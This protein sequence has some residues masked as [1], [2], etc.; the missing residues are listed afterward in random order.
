MVLSVILCTHNPRRDYLDRTLAALQTQS[1]DKGK[2]ELLVI[3]NDSHPPLR[4]GLDLSWH[5][6][7]RI[8]EEPDLGIL[9][10]RVRGLR[11]ASAS[12]MLFVDDDNVLAPDYLETALEIANLHP[13]LGCWGGSLT[14][15]F[16]VPPPPWIETFKLFLACV[17]VPEDRWSNLRFSHAT[18]PPTAGMCL[19]RAVAKQFIHLVETDPRRQLLGRRGKTGLTNG[20]DA[21]LAYTACDIGL[22]TGQFARLK[23]T[24]LIPA[25]RLELNYLLRF[26]EGTYFSSL[27]LQA[28]RGRKPEPNASSAPRAMIGGLRR[29]LFWNRWHRKLF[30]C[31]LRA[32]QRA[33][34]VVADWR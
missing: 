13:F 18:L 34:E 10:A 17:D 15:E 29:R 2:W 23:M 33:C 5:P 6:S 8:V 11:E 1:Y 7:A 28:L 22:G 21:D 4:E 27:I 16:E 14:P 26:A 32:H 20:E 31:Q 30:E 9:P 12:L 24:H 3:D 19:R 25:G